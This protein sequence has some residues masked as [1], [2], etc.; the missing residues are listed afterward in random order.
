MGGRGEPAAVRAA[1]EGRGPTG[2]SRRRWREGGRVSTAACGRRTWGAGGGR[3][4]G[5]RGQRRLV[6]EGGRGEAAAEVSE[7]LF[8]RFA[9]DH[10]AIAIAIS[11]VKVEVAAAACFFRPPPFPSSSHCFSRPPLFP[12]SSHC[13]SRPTPPAGRRRS[14]A[15]DVS[16]P[17]A[18]DVSMPGAGCSS[19]RSPP[20]LQPPPLAPRGRL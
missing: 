3:R 11:G 10:A 9:A 1:T 20:Q 14:A 18:D 8:G 4:A 16:M 7:F 12:S 2:Q 19:P 6:V 13:F 17:A 15:A 5:G